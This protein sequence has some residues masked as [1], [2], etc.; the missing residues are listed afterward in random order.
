MITIVHISD[1]HFG[2]VE[3]GAVEALRRAIERI[4]PAVVVASGDLTMRARRREFREAAAF[5]ES[6]P[7]P[8]VATPGNHDVPA[9]NVAERFAAPL[10]AYRRAIDPVAKDALRV[11]GLTLA[12][13]N[14]ARSWGM[15]W[16]WA[17]GRFSGRQVAR[18]E[19]VFG[20]AEEGDWRGLVTH[21]PFEIPEEM[22]G[23]RP[24]G[25]GAP[26]LEA[27]TRAK[28]DF[29]LCGHLHRRSWGL[30]AHVERIKGRSVLLVQASTAL[31]D[32][33]RD[34]PN[35][36]NVLE[37]GE[38]RLTATVWERGGETFEPAASEAYE[39]TAGGLKRTE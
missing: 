38:D 5:L 33:R 25:R 24:V 8:V 32:R 15:H 30:A 16:N 34:E 26:M 2:R 27:L 39:W 7:A 4:A 9:W 17:H 21:H 19:S 12:S 14:S 10:R 36:F 29:V 23:F 3:V 22:R 20:A 28:V 37:L 11:D 18:V 1:L 31:S 35:S 6:L 13:M